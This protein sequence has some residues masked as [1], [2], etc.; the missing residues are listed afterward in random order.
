[1]RSVWVIGGGGLLG[2]ALSRELMISS[3]VFRP[4]VALDWSDPNALSFQVEAAVRE[5]GSSIGVS[6]RWEIYWS[7]GIGNMG[8]SSEQLE[9][10][11]KALRAMLG[12]LS[13][14]E[15]LC[16]CG[17]SLAFA[18]SAGALY[19]GTTDDLVT[20]H[21]AL[22]PTTPYAFA[23]L[24][25]EALLGDFSRRQPIH[26][27]LIA[28]IST[29]F[30]A[31][32]PGRDPRGLF[33]V[34]ARSIYSHEPVKIFVPLDTMRDYI[35]SDDAARSMIDA[36][37]CI[38]ES[39]PLLVKIVASQRITT[40]AEIVALFGRIGRRHLRVVTG[41][42]AMTSKYAGL[43]QFRSSVGPDTAE[44]YKST[45]HVCVAR[46]LEAE[47]LSYVMPKPRYR[48]S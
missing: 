18:S 5:F 2:S 1:M 45:L 12:A 17:G 29:L 25:Q 21:S 36:L 16:A 42:T 27:V 44:K 46:I 28:R 30:G 33:G 31:G 19:A 26:R 8:S 11:T 37:R 23:K 35:Y 38:P 39:D 40:I 9:C 32:R 48:S 13:G 4:R 47:R 20:E 15:H 14:N 41:A 43:M 10:E 6:S 22:A 24:E 3:T 34:M 7:A